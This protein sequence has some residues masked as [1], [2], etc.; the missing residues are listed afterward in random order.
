[1]ALSIKKV[2]FPHLMSSISAWKAPRSFVSGQNA[3]KGPNSFLK[4]R[5]A[6]TFEKRFF[7]VGGNYLSAKDG[8]SKD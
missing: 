2:F 5:H 6:Q 4:A 7:G 1:M 3:A 8:L